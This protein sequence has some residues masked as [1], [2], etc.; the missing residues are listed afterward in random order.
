VKL[1][2]FPLHRFLL[3]GVVLELEGIPLEKTKVQVASTIK[4]VNRSVEAVT[5]LVF[6][7]SLFL[8]RP[9]SLLPLCTGF[10]ALFLSSSLSSTRFT[11]SCDFFFPL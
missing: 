10:D 3:D 5:F 4:I 6:V 8:P 7:V 2:G 11:V 9:I 1:K